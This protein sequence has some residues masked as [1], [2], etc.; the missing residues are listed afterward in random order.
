LSGQQSTLAGESFEQLRKVDDGL[1]VTGLLGGAYTGGMTTRTMRINIPTDPSGYL[2]RECP[3]C[4][5][6]FKVMPGTGLAAIDQCYCAYCGHKGANDTFWTKAQIEY[7]R[8]IVANTFM[9]EALQTLKR[10]EFNIKPKGAFGIGFR[11]TVTGSPTP[12]RIYVEPSLETELVCDTCTLKYAIYGVFAFCPDCG[13]H[14]SLLILYKN[15]DFV[16]KLLTFAETTDADTRERLTQDALE[17]AISTFDGFGREVCRFLAEKKNIPTASNISFQNLASAHDALSR[18][19][20]VDI[21]TGLS[22]DEW[23]FLVTAFQKRHLI[24]HKMGVIDQEYLDVTKDR[25]AV[26]GRKVSVTGAEVQQACELL[27]RIGTA[28]AAGQS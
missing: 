10:H 3:K 11:L 21:R 28:L 26:V 22:D 2:A 27:G 5:G 23:L 1:H 20:S 7:A 19:F 14:N 18:H 15:F 24:A 16:R 4:E 9:T 25:S 8:S 17:N 12:I 6:T 13:A